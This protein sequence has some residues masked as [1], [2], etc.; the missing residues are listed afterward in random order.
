MFTLS[1]I[2][3]GIFSAGRD[4]IHRVSTNKPNRFLQGFFDFF[5]KIKKGIFSNLQENVPFIIENPN[6]STAVQSLL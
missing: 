2:L 4:A 1:K 5:S 6:L 3:A